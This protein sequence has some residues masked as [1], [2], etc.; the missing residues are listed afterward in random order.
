M[1]AIKMMYSTYRTDSAKKV[2]I[3]I[4]KSLDIII[5]T[6]LETHFPMT[7]L[8]V[9]SDLYDQLDKHHSP[10]MTIVMAT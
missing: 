9:Q 2:A 4:K 1:E 8:F 3:P 5:K 6:L 7:I 10:R